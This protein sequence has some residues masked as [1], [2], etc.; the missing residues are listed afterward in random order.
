V[1]ITALKERT[2][3]LAPGGGLRIDQPTAIGEDAAGELHF[4]DFD[5]EIYTLVP[6]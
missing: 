4:V 3:A 6:R 5:G 1:R 2:A